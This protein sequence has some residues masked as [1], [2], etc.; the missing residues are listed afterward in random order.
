MRVLLFLA[1]GVAIVA[2]LLRI[3]LRTRPGDLARRLRMVGG[4]VLIALGGGLLYL[5]QIALALPVAMAGV[6][7]LRRHAAVRPAGPSGK[8]SGVSSQALSMT[9]DHDTGAM[10]GTVL[11]GEHAGRNLASLSLAAL[12]GLAED[13]R[14]D[15]ESL[16]LLESYIDR[17]HPGWRDDIQADPDGRQSAPATT[18]GVSLQEAYKVLGLEQG[19]GEAEVREA[20]RRLMKQ[21]HPDRGGSATL[22]AQINEAKDRILGQHR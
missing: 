20:H 11:T 8:R 2:L 17:A 6:M 14:G 4:F 12:I 16:R 9:L 10:D 3:F 15:P 1:V 5:R 21:V 7:M 18:G 13:L 19:A 22:A